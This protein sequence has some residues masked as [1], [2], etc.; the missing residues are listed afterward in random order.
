MSDIYIP[1]VHIGSCIRNRIKEL[2]I[3]K[4]EFGRRIGV[5]Q[6]H[7]YRLLEKTSIDTE[8]LVQISI[9]LEYNFFMYYCAQPDGINAPESAVNTGKG[10]ANNAN[11]NIS[12]GNT[13][14]NAPHSAVNLG[15]G[16]AIHIDGECFE[17]IQKSQIRYYEEIIAQL[18]SQISDKQKIIELLDKQQ[19][20]SRGVP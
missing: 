3:T 11:G 4:T 2:G 1:K 18:K 14:I 17:H 15:E 13:S 6:Q 16:G 9:A 19:M 10:T 7:V 12:S 5:L 8:R 20:E